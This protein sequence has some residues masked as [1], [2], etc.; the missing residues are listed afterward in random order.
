MRFFRYLFRSVLSVF[1]FKF[2]EYC[3]SFL[4]GDARKCSDCGSIVRDADV[5]SW[6]WCAVGAMLSPVGLIA[7]IVFLCKKKKERAASAFAGALIQLAL[8]G[9]AVALFMIMQGKGISLI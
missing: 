6:G 1:G 9:A 8:A 5:F 7:G 2:C 3:G 4:R